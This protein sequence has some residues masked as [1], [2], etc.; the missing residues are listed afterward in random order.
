MITAALAALLLLPGSSPAADD[1]PHKD[2]ICVSTGKSDG[3]CPNYDW[4]YKQAN[5]KWQTLN[6][7]TLFSYR[8]C[9]DFVALRLGLK[10]SQFKFASGKG[11]AIDWKEYATNAGFTV[12]QTPAVGD[13]A[14]WGSDRGYGKYGH[15][16]IVTK[17]NS[18]GSAAIEGYNGVGTGVYEA[19]ASVQAD[20]YLHRD[21]AS[22]RSGTS[23]SPTRQGPRCVPGSFSGRP[24]FTAFVTYCRNTVR[25]RALGRAYVLQGGAC[26]VSKGAINFTI[27]NVDKRLH[28]G[29]NV[30]APILPNE[31]LAPRGGTFTSRP[32]NLV[33]GFILLPNGY[34][35]E[36]LPYPWVIPVPKSWIRLA[37]DR[38]S[39]TLR[40]VE[41]TGKA[42]AV[43]SFVC[44]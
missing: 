1:Y 19:K 36:L 27:G 25:I 13:I 21:A 37:A 20:A 30:G 6:P 23:K 7:T 9:T 42:L 26:Q 16:A 34:Q 38:R 31:Q 35:G 44:A 33:T 5:G 12:T 28:V 8:N 32:R 24:G 11:N 14:W 2:A 41:E 10:W 4:G 39:G 29:F 22:S 43:A 18:D 15:V 3:K 40:T 17:V